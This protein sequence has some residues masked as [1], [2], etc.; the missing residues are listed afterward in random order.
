MNK[1]IKVG[2]CI[3]ISSDGQGIV[4]I[5]NKKTFVPS[6]L[7]GEEAEIEILYRKK[8]FNVGKINKLITKSSFRIV[9][10][11]KCS[12]ACGGCCFQ[13]LDYNEELR[14]KKEN[15]INIIKSMAN[16][17]AKEAKIIGMDN[18]YNYRNKIQ[19]PFGYDKQ[20]RLVYGFYRIKSHDIIPIEECAIEDS[21]HK[22]I[23]KDISILMKDMKISAYNEDLDSGV[24]RHCLLRVGKNSGEIMVVLITRVYGFPSKQNF[25]KALKERHPEITT[26]IQNINDRK[27]NVILGNKEYVLYGKGYIEDSLLGVKFKISSKS[28]Y[29]INHDQC[30]KL[31]SLALTKAKLTKDDE[32]V[33]L[34][35]GIGTIGLIASKYVKS[36]VGVEVVE[37]AIIDSK[38]NAKINNINNAKFICDDASNFLLKKA[39]DCVFVDPPRKGLDNKVIKALINSH[40]KRIIYISCDVSTLARDINILKNYFNIESI[41]FVD[42]FP[43]TFH[44]ETMVSLSLKK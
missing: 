14:I 11:C 8:D 27:T 15:A 22:A 38:E 17:N 40:P 39:Y 7:I 23:L 3:N 4:Y 31:Y 42:M 34:Y 16:I 25:I 26:I 36:V 5:D 30:E 6:L 33:D 37:E 10:K 44:V 29:Q 2:K 9:P 13:N 12:T 43:R 32:I 24:L 19:V 18:P 35:C 28:F 41:D 1:E 20:N 21:S